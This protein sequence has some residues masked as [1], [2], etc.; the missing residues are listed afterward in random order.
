MD[1]KE[2]DLPDMKVEGTLEVAELTKK[3]AD[4][5]IPFI[6]TIQEEATT[7][8]HVAELSRVILAGENADEDQIKAA[9]LVLRLYKNE[10]AKETKSLL[11]QCNT[12][13]AE[14]NDKAIE[15]QHK[16]ARNSVL[17]SPFFLQRSLLEAYY[18]IKA[19]IWDEARKINK[20]PVMPFAKEELQ[21]LISDDE[22]GQF[23]KYSIDR[24]RKNALESGPKED[25][26]PEPEET[27]KK[28]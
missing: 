22:L 11:V 4:E 2:V 28:K 6:T 25:K 20:R 24:I 3:Y 10:P 18:M 27:I 1:G 19:Y 26:T 13:F 23:A 21:T 9:N 15:Y 14:L 5:F 12:L 16:M 17:T 8:L 7:R